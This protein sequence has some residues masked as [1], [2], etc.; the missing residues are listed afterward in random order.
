[1]GLGAPQLPDAAGKPE[2]AK[3]IF[4]KEVAENL[5]AEGNAHL[6]R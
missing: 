3:E 6:G 1:M 2:R 4:P 5:V